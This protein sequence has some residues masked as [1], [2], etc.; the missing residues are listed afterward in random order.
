MGIPHFGGTQFMGRKGMVKLTLPC[1]HQTAEFITQ[2]IYQTVKLEKFPHSPIYL[3][4]MR[5]IVFQDE[6]FPSVLN[7]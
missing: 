1:I 2:Q 7:I 4:C 6:I 3:L 5:S